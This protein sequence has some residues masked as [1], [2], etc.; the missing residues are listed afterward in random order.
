MIQEQIIAKLQAAFAPQHL[1]VINESHRHN[2]PPGSESHF[3]VVL[4]S[5]AFCAQR[6]LPR[7]RAVNTVL[8][9]E[10]ANHIHA[11]S[12]HTY[13]PEEWATT[14]GGFPE[15]PQCLGGNQR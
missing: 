4:V 1:E 12:L 9:D 5:D 15:S 10:L 6:L 2:V 14:Q 3:K 11:L 8:A 7:H 13:T